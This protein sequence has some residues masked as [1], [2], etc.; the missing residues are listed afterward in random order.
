MNQCSMSSYKSIYILTYDNINL[1]LIAKEDCYKF[2]L[3]DICD[4]ALYYTPIGT[5]VSKI[6][7]ESTIKKVNVDGLPQTLNSLQLSLANY[8][9]N[10]F[11]EDNYQEV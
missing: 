1:P 10:L 9:I 2:G 7:I 8:L 4:T 3:E 5:P 6:P 11:I